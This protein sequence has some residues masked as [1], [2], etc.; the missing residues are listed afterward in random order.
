MQVLDHSA[1]VSIPAAP[2]TVPSMQ[3]PP[4]TVYSQPQSRLPASQPESVPAF[5]NRRVGQATETRGPESRP[6]APASRFPTRE[7]SSTF[8]AFDTDWDVPAFQRKGGQ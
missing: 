1:R 8:P 5:S 6:A 7:R 3:A 4:R 2:A